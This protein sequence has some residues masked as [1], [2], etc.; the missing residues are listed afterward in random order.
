LKIPEIIRS[1]VSVC[2]TESVRKMLMIKKLR[3][4]KSIVK[5]IA[6]TRGEPEMLVSIA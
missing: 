3:N 6:E 1:S 4:V 5:R 2:P